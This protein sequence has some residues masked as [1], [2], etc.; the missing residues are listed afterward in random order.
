MLE[1]SVGTLKTSLSLAEPWQLGS[2]GRQQQCYQFLFLCNFPP[3]GTPWY[4]ECTR[5]C[6]RSTFSFPLFLSHHLFGCASIH[7]NVFT[8]CQ[9]PG[10]STLFGSRERRD[11]VIT[12]RRLLEEKMGRVSVTITKETVCSR[13]E[14][15]DSARSLRI[16]G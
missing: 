3:L 9:N 8:R 5:I 7:W 11:E 16:Y 1:V 2:G 6:Q 4:L 10:N 13:L 15:K 12:H 14:S